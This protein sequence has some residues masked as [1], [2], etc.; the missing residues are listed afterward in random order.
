[1]W[2]VKM[3]SNFNC[4]IKQKRIFLNRKFF[5]YLG[6]V[7]Q[8]RFPEMELLIQREEI[9]EGI[10]Y[11]FFSKIFATICIPFYNIWTYP[12]YCALTFLAVRILIKNKLCLLICWEEMTFYCHFNLQVFD[13][14]S[15]GIVSICSFISWCLAFMIF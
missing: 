7:P 15:V 12:F 14:Y 6:L 11:Q 8:D 13:Y 10:C 5:H 1:M 2:H 3:V 4:Y 9:F